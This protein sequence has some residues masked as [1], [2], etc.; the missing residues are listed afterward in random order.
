MTATH[1]ATPGDAMHGPDRPSWRM[2]IGRFRRDGAF[3]GDLLLRTAPF[4]AGGL[5]LLSVSGGVTTPLLVWAMA[6]LIDTIPQLQGKAVDPWP[7]TAPWLAALAVA[8][9]WNGLSQPAITYWTAIVRERINAKL[10]RR[11]LEH[12]VALPLATFEQLDFYTKLNTAQSA[13]DS[14]VVGLLRGLAGTAGT[15]ASIT[16]LLLLFAR[17]SPLLAAAL[18]A[19]SVTGAVITARFVRRFNR[20]RDTSADGRESGYWEAVLTS[21]QLA[22]E[23]RLGA[24]AGPFLDRWRH[25]TRRYVAGFMG[26]RRRAVQQ[27]AITSIL[28]EAVNWAGV[29][30]LLLLA[31]RRDI[32]LGSLVALLFGLGQ[33]RDASVNLAAEVGG[34][35]RL[36]LPVTYLR[37]FLDLATEPPAGQGEPAPR[38]LRH[39]VEFRHVSFTYPGADRPALTDVQ[40]LL[41]PGEHVA[42]V[43]ENGAGKTTL[44]RLLL[45]LYRPTTGTITVDGVDLAD[46]DPAAWRREATAIFQDFV[47]YPTTVLEN[48]AYA[49]ASALADGDINSIGQSPPA[50]VTAAATASDAHPFITALP[51]GYATLLGKEFEGAADLSTGQ[52]QR[53]SLAR[54]YLRAAQLVVL[55]EPTAA[56]DP[57]GEA[58]VYRQFADAARGRCAVFI[59]HRLGSARLADRIVVLQAGRIVE[60]GSHD[61]LLQTGGEYARMFRLQAAWYTADGANPTGVT[62]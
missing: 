13:L 52:W 15:L 47:R 21:R 20:A 51:H 3:A 55:D 23:L 45:G 2:A 1:S 35:V 32:S 4:A 61:V 39:G 46:L 62:P 57:M 60:E 40:L 33:N 50:R 31:L 12:A 37:Q 36:W 54:A 8:I 11:F 56:L 27:R 38:P 25:A 49:D 59:S 53:L 42:L 16:G 10:Q 41:R 26:A 43:G 34:L 6:G 5:L 7:L 58:A 14:P 24:L 29:L 9:L 17:A 18:L 28:L 44:V 48:V 22:P 19:A 30:L